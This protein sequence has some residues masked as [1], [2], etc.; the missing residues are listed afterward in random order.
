[1]DREKSESAK[2]QKDVTTAQTAAGREQQ[3]YQ[4]ALDAD[5]KADAKKKKNNP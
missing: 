5:R 1:M 2:A 3:Q 4:R